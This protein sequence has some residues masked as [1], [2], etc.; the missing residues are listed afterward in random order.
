VYRAV[1]GH[2][3][4]TAAAAS[5]AVLGEPCGRDLAE[6][7]VV[8]MLLFGLLQERP[9]PEL[10]RSQPTEETEG[11]DLLRRPAELAFP[12]HTAAVQAFFEERY[13]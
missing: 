9:A 11:W 7:P 3:N 10:P 8:A 6:L 12:L 4:E 2:R 5:S 1:A 13:L